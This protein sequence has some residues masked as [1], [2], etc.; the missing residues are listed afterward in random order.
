[1][2]VDAK[3]LLPVD[4]TEHLIQNDSYSVAQCLRSIKEVLGLKEKDAE[5]QIYEWLGAAIQEKQCEP[6]LKQKK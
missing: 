6:S 1:M 3:N 5:K 2:A 4:I